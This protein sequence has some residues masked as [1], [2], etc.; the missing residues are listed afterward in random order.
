MPGYGARIRMAMQ[1]VSRYHGASPTRAGGTNSRHGLTLEEPPSPRP[2]TPSEPR[3]LE[4]LMPTSPTPAA[5]RPADLLRAAA[6]LLREAAGHATPGPWRTHDTHL[7]GV[8]GHTATVLTDRP[9]LNDTELIAWLPTMSH[10]PW[11]EARNVWRNAGW[12][13]LMHPGVGLALAAWLESAAE[14][15]GDTEASL[16]TLLDPPALAVAQQ[17]LGTSTAAAPAVD[18]QEPVQL[19]WGLDDVMYGDDDT[20][21]VLLSGPGREPYWVE[22]DPE[23]T[24]ALREALAGPAA[25]PASADRAA[26]RDR[27]RR[28]VCEAEGFAWDTDMLE[29]DEYGEVADAVLAVLDTPAD[30]AAVLTEPEQTM[31]NYALNQAQLRI[32]SGHGSHTEEE[33]AA[34]V[35][36][37][38]LADAAA[39]VQPPT[40]TADRAA[41]L[42]MTPTEY[43]QHSHTTAIQQIQAAA[44]GL[45]AE[46]AIRVADALK[47][48]AKACT[49]DF[50]DEPWIR[51]QHADDCPAAP[52]A[53]EEQR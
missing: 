24:A 47:E 32:W 23:R 29:P 28:A 1:Y 48:P 36:L 5:D 8:G 7:G 19:R 15:L 21:T 35:S 31:L 53:P 18:E 33:Q 39:G 14:R 2:R 26:P 20:T 6:E 34:L 45:L 4:P 43:R 50:I 11:D 49:C 9:N 22:L 12:M 44:Q 42:G 10:E 27:I 40:T 37:R 51:M 16:A 3:H 38:R 52:A 13:A 25:P 41:A 30:R 46:T 17:L